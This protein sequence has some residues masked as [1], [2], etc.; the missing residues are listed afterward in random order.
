[1][2]VSSCLS[3]PWLGRSEGSAGGDNVALWPTQLWLHPSAGPRVRLRPSLCPV[4]DSDDLWGHH[5]VERVG[6]WDRGSLVTT[7]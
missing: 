3:V 2:R 6:C 4:A 1:M 5:G 7:G